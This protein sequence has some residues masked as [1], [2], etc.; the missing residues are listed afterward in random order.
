[1]KKNIAALFLAALFCRADCTEWDHPLWLGRG[2]VW[3]ARFPVVISNPSDKPLAGAP[4]TV[5]VGGGPGQAPLAGARAEAV[6]VTDARGVQLLYA[7]RDPA[8]REIITAGAVPDGAELVLPA[9]CA[10]A[11]SVTY[12]VYFDNPGAWALADFFTETPAGDINGGFETGKR[13][14]VTETRAGAVERLRLRDVGVE[15]DW[16]AHMLGNAGLLGRL[17][18]FTRTGKREW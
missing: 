6:R 16:P 12:R 2:D 4:V 9:V 17:L 1:M 7:L 14:P 5:I 10:P 15:A 8:S 3:R 18:P 11:T 13:L